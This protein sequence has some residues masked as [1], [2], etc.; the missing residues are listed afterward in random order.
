MNANGENVAVIMLTLNQREMTTECLSSLTS[1]NDL[2]FRILVW[3]NGSQD[4]TVDAVREHFPD[5]LVHYHPEN[6]GVAPG[7]NAAAEQ[8]INMLEPTH[9]LFL[10]NDMIVEPGFVRALLEP[11]AQDQL[12]GQTHATIALPLV[13]KA[14]LERW[15]WL[16][17]HLLARADETRR[18][19]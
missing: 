8:A 2:P 19:R 15:R 14:T 7:R 1:S 6:L 5:V 16:P 13:V 17:G 10:D 12:V 4:G 3:D 9:L 18:L 11:F